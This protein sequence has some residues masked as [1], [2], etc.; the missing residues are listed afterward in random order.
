MV[1]ESRH[2]AACLRVTSWATWPP[3][4]VPSGDEMGRHV[5]RAALGECRSMQ[6]RRREASCR[7]T[8][9]QRAG[10]EGCWHHE[11]GYSARW[12]RSGAWRVTIPTAEGAALPPPEL[13]SGEQRSFDRLRLFQ[14]DGGRCREASCRCLGRIGQGRST[15]STSGSPAANRARAW[16]NADSR[17]PCRCALDV[18][19]QRSQRTRGGGPC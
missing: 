15:I 17:R 1:G 11:L 12:R 10:G 18:F 13:R 8:G 9:S 2:V 5:A 7:E 16:G 19:P 6:L 14:D 4:A 3:C